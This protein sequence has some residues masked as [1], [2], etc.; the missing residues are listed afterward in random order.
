MY[1]QMDKW[2]DVRYMNAWEGEWADG[3]MC[4]CIR[5]HAWKDGWMDEKSDVL[6]D[7]LLSEQLG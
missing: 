7:R 2:T 3:W 5:V 6:G 1:R 4:A